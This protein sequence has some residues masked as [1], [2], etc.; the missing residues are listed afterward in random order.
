MRPAPEDTARPAAQPDAGPTQ[1]PH[2]A[3]VLDR[4][5]LA[6]SASAYELES[7]AHGAISASVIVVDT[8]PG[9]GPRLHSLREMT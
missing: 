1:A 5:A 3:R 9:S 2:G 6:S 8:P 7:D 4:T